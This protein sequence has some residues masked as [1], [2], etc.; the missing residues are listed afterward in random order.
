M[1]IVSNRHYINI[2]AVIIEIIFEIRLYKFEFNKKYLI[3]FRYAKNIIIHDQRRG[4][5]LKKVMSVGNE[6][7][8]HRKAG[9]FI[10]VIWSKPSREIRFE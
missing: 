6:N 2:T 7:Q 10:T 3:I 5:M 1:I 4:S 8:F 9:F